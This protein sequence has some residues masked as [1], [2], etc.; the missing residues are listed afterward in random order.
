[1]VEGDTSQP[2]V[3]TLYEAD[4]SNVSAFT[5]APENDAIYLENSSDVSVI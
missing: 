5:A 2:V 3:T 4:M 1:M